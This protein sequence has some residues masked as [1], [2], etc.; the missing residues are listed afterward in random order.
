MGQYSLD[1][2]KKNID[3]KFT[4]RLVWHRIRKE[5]C[6]IAHPKK[7]IRMLMLREDACRKCGKQSYCCIETLEKTPFN[8]RHL[9][10]DGTCKIHL[11]KGYPLAC[12]IFPF[13]EKDDIVNDCKLVN[14]VKR[15]SR[16]CGLEVVNTEQ[17]KRCLRF[18]SV[19]IMPI[20]FVAAGALFGKS[21]SL[22]YIYCIGL[23]IGF[24]LFKIIFEIN[25]RCNKSA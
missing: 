19:A 7:I 15:V 20:S 6:M 23:I 22:I 2:S 9:N 12:Y 13:D 5:Y 1:F 24:L 16:E 25:N 21:M 3:W 8:C 14:E 17:E 11:T 10:K 4:A 18:I